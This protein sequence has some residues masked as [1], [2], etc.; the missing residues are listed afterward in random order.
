MK[1]KRSPIS[2]IFFLNLLITPIYQLIPQNNMQIKH[3][4]LTQVIQA[5]DLKKIFFLVVSVWIISINHLHVDFAQLYQIYWWACQ[6]N[7]LLLLLLI[8]R[9]SLG[10]FLAV[11]TSL[12]NF[13]ICSHMSIFP[14]KPF[15]IS[16]IATVKPLSDS[17]NIWVLF[18]SCAYV[19][20][21]VSRVRLFA[22][23]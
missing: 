12:M 7:V 21:H 22:I 17:S 1:H 15:G 16:I 3:F 10:L 19:L 20:S 18:E 2:M 13:P 5:L 11:F 23:P 14:M 8:S 4:K 6:R 9:I